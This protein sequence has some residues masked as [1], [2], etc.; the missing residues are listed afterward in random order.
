MTV[1][2][3]DVIDI[4]SFGEANCILTIADHLPWDKVEEHLVCLQE[5][6][7][8]Y[9]DFVRSGEL[10]EKYPKARGLPVLISIVMKY[11]A[12]EHAQWFFTKVEPVIENEGLQLEMK[13]R[14][15]RLSS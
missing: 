7:N 6:L 5:K 3:P 4:V 2:Q 14:P 8:T 15:S 11:P 10:Y 13:H 1:E 12:P 9:L